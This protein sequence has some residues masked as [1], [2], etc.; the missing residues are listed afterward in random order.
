M[1]CFVCEQHGEHQTA[2]AVC[3][4]CGVALCMDHLAEREGYQVGGMSHPCP[5]TAPRTRT[6]AEKG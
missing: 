2:V 3:S 1:N 4:N 6:A 5:H